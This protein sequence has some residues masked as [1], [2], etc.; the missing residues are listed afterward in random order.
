MPANF[1]SLFISLAKENKECE[2]RP[3]R[4]KASE[5][6]HDKTRHETTQDTTREGTEEAKGDSARG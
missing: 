6:S 5:D 2:Q 1:L 4:F 3:I